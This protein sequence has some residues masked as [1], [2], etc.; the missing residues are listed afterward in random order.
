[1]EKPPAWHLTKGIRKRQVIDEAR[2]KG[3]N[4]QNASLMDLCHLNNS[5]LEPKFQKHKGR[6]AFRGDIVRDVSE[7]YAEFSEQG[8]AHS[9]VAAA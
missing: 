8:S 7:S 3:R 9:Q 5:E 1:M 4:F 2:N 6:V